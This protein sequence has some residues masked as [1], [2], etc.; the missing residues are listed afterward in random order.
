MYE[1]QTVTDVKSVRGFHEKYHKPERY[2]GRGTEYVAA[3]LASSDREIA[4]YGYTIITHHDS[5]TGKT[6]CYRG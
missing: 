5:I 1:P 2:T 3:V 6:I 4:D